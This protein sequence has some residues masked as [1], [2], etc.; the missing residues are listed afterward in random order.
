MPSMTSSRVAAA[1]CDLS[2]SSATSA[3]R[4]ATFI[5]ASRR[6]FD[7]LLDAA[8]DLV[9]LVGE[10]FRRGDDLLHLLAGHGI[11]VEILL[12]RLRE[13]GWVLH[14]RVEGITQRLDPLW[15]DVGRR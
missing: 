6:L 7:V 4:G 13:E 12:L 5:D 11:D 14:R 1:S 10:R 3:G 2:R 8:D 9:E 15:R